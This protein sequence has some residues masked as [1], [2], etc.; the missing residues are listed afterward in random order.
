[1]KLKKFKAVYHVGQIRIE[2]WIAVF[3]R[4]GETPDIIAK[5]KRYFYEVE[6]CPDLPDPPDIPF[7]KYL[8]TGPGWKTEL[9]V[10]IDGRLEVGP[11][12]KELTFPS[13][14]RYR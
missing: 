9:S 12:L 5:Y 4:E 7:Q 6:E 3:C 13:C 14:Y 2:N 8:I 10:N 11:R 1:M